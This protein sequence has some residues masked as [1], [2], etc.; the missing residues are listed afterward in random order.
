MFE[1]FSEK[2]I[3]GT[4]IFL[5]WEILAIGTIVNI[6]MKSRSAASAWIQAPAQ[7]A[8]NPETPWARSPAM[9][10]ARISP[11]PAVASQGGALSVTAARPSG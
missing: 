9:K 4:L 2:A 8:S 1:Q 11:D 5:G 3:V 7:A 6:V 10:P